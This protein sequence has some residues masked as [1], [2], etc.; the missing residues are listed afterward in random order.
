MPERHIFTSLPIR[1]AGRS[2]V[3]RLCG[4]CTL[5]RHNDTVVL[6][7]LKLKAEDDALIEIDSRE[8]IWGFVSQELQKSV[9]EEA[10]PPLAEEPYNPQSP[11]DLD[12]AMTEG[13]RSA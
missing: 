1:V 8:P 13:A 12:N 10:L 3:A 9:I 6:R 2:V 5:V 7:E 4:E 11:G